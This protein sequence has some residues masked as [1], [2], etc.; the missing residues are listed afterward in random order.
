MSR[1]N[2]VTK[3]GLMELARLTHEYLDRNAKAA[4]VSVS[5]RW[6]SQMIKPYRVYG[7]FSGLE[8]IGKIRARRSK[9]KKL[10]LSNGFSPLIN[11][12]R[13]WRVGRVFKVFRTIFPVVPSGGTHLNVK[14]QL[15]NAYFCAN[16]HRSGYYNHRLTSVDINM[17]LHPHW[18]RRLSAVCLKMNRFFLEVVELPAKA[19]GLKVALWGLEVHKGRGYTFRCSWVPFTDKEIKENAL[20]RLEPWQTVGLL[21]LDLP[22][23]GGSILRGAAVAA[24]Q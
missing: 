13:R 6:I 11:R 17:R 9:R 14:W 8:V 21:G 7:Y 10:Q 18:H 4:S 2:P 16:S 24:G 19:N 22:P 23:V 12:L 5:A 3:L 15:G 20:D 1:V